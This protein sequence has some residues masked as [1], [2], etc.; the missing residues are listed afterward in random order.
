MPTQLRQGIVEIETLRRYGRVPIGTHARGPMILE[1]YDK[2]SYWVS[3]TISIADDP[4]KLKVSCGINVFSGKPG[5][6]VRLKRYV[7]GV[8]TPFE[9]TLEE[10]AVASVTDS[11]VEM[12][13]PGGYQRFRVV[14]AEWAGP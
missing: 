1:K 14:R 5:E 10:Y 7:R 9:G 8:L 3:Y 4:R 12:N 6:V 2:A 13:T 11:L